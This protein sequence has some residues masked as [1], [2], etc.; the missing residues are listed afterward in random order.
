M[1][2]EAGQ[3]AAK[4]PDRIVRSIRETR[5]QAVRIAEA[6]GIDKSAVYQWKKVPPHWVHI[7][8]KVI[9]LPPEKIRP[10]VFKQAKKG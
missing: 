2:M 1:N 6:C 9:G 4:E 5:G 7:V 10:D 3:M 8:S